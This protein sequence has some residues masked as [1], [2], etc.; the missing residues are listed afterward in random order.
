MSSDEI[1]RRLVLRMVSEASRVL[2]EGIVRRESDLD[3]AMVLGMGFPDFRGGLLRHARELGLGNVLTELKELAKRYGERFTPCAEME[4]AL[5][6]RHLWS[7][8]TSKR[9]RR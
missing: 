8:K 3:V 6:W 4:G 9:P 7:E 1:T 5:P 2:A